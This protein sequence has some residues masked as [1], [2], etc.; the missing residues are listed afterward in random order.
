MTCPLRRPRYPPPMCVTHKQKAA[1]LIMKALLLFTILG[2]MATA[3]FGLDAPYTSLPAGISFSFMERFE[4]N[5]RQAAFLSLSV[6]SSG[7][8]HGDL[9]YN[10]AAKSTG[11]RDRKIRGRITKRL[12]LS[13]HAMEFEIDLKLGEGQRLIGSFSR[14]AHPGISNSFNYV[15]R[16]KGVLSDA[17]I[18]FEDREHF[19]TRSTFTVYV[20]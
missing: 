13:P 15:N 5:H 18:F 6:E 2:G 4:P 20:D 3:S 11:H 12:K 7:R 16:L 9:T 10:D 17:S 14:R 1:K 19:H 8:I